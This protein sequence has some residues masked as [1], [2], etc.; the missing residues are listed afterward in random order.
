MKSTTFKV[1]PRPD[2]EYKKKDS[3]DFQMQKSAIYQ[4]R[5]NSTYVTFY[6]WCAY[7]L[8]GIVTGLVCFIWEVGV[9]SAV[10]L[11]WRAAQTVLKDTFGDIFGSYSIY[12]ALSLFF[13]MGASILTL[14]LEPLAAGGGTTEMMGYFNG[15][16][17]PGVFSFKTL[18]VKIFGLM[19][20]IAAG[21]CIGKEGVLAHI[22]SIIGY[23]ILYLPF[24]FVDYFRNPEDKRDIAA[25]GTA[26][27]V[28]AAFGSPIGG[29]MFAYEIAAPT[30]FWT[31]E[32][33]W[34]LFFTSAIS[35]FTVNI[36]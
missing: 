28:A 29:T 17:Y 4:T 19:F 6:K 25:A 7:A 31:F 24:G 36:C 13:G 27:G 1:Y 11:K 2:Q 3:I 5:P 12:I 14:K 18:T 32:L 30:V 34:M 23:A 21:L 20:A 16:N 22:G 15:V 33:T 9:E 26:A 8:T 10:E 35:C